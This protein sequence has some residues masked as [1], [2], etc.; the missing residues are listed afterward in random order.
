MAASDADSTLKLKR[1]EEIITKV[2]EMLLTAGLALFAAL[3][4]ALF[5]S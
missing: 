4:P 3:R 2:L 5:A 1:L